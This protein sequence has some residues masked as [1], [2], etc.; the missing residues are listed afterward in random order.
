MTKVIPLTKGAE[1]IVDDE[2]FERVSQFKWSL[3]GHGDFKCARR[4]IYSPYINGK[5]VSRGERMHKFILGIPPGRKVIVDHINRN[6]LD[7]RKSNLRVTDFHGNNR[8][9]RPLKNKS[10]QYKGV[11]YYKRDSAWTASIRVNGKGIRIGK[12]DSEIDAANAYD[13]AALEHFGEFAYLNLGSRGSE[14][15][16]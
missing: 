15:I 13:K 8:N 12:Y 3:G 14:C 11:S 10:S 16:A 2:D 1:A 4:H 6:A 5:R 7:N 9:R